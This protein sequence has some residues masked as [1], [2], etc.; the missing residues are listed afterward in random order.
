MM[1]DMK[2]LIEKLDY[3]WGSEGFL[4]NV[5]NGQFSHE[6]GASFLSISD[7]WGQVFYYHISQKY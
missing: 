1:T 7:I 3:E 6:S 2:Q 4:G 5:R